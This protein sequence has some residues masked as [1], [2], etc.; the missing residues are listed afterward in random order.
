[1]DTVTIK[2]VHVP[3]AYVASEESALVRF[4]SGSPA[5]PTFTPPRPYERGVNGRSTLVQNA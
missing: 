4:L 2:V 1:M 3:P 5:L